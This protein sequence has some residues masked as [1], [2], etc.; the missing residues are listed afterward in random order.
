MDEEVDYNN[1][2]VCYCTRCCSL[3]ILDFGTTTV[4]CDDCGGTDI[5]T[6]TIDEWDIIYFKRYGKHYLNTKD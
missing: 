2:P 1:E 3:N 6:V 5:G 4:F